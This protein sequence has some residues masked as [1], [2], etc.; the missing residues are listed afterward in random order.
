MQE[1]KHNVEQKHNIVLE[2]VYEHVYECFYSF[3]GAA[4]DYSIYYP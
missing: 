1:V 4:A 2:H 3:S